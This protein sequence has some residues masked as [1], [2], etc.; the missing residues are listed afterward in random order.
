[1]KLSNFEVRKEVEISCDVFWS[2]F[3]S[4]H[5]DNHSFL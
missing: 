3:V 2:G 4:Y 1:M 5:D